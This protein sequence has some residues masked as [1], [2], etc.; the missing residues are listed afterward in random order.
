MKYSARLIHNKEINRLGNQTTKTGGRKYQWKT[1]NSRDDYDA[2]ID[3]LKE[4][5]KIVKFYKSTTM[6]TG[7][8]SY[9]VLYSQIKRG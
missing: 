4:R 5:Y 8:Y 6:I 2:I 1:L 9:F 7:I 3:D